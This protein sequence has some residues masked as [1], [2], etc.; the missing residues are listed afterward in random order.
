VWSYLHA[1]G[2]AGDIGHAR[3]MALT[4]LLVAS[5]GMTAAL[6]RLRQAPARW[7]VAGTLASVGMLVQVPVMSRLVNLRPLHGADWLLVAVA[8]GVIGIATVALASRLRHS[9]E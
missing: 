7:L 2:A 9:P 8:L 4:V 5:A 3:A 1:L 6:T